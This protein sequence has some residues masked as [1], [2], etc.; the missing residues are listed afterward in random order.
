MMQGGIWLHGP[1]N[2]LHFHICKIITKSCNQILGDLS[3]QPIWKYKRT[4]KPQIKITSQSN[5]RKP[6]KNLKLKRQL[7]IESER[8]WMSNEVQII[9]FSLDKI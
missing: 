9:S 6:A 3:F 8:W 2:V 4:I 7:N 5:D 1:T